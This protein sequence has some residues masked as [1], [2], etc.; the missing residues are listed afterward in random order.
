M[1]KKHF[2][3]FLRWELWMHG[4]SHFIE[5]F[6]AIHEEVCVTASIAT[7]FFTFL[8]ILTSFYISKKHVYLKP[9]E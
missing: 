1:L 4:V 3:G 5:V 2:L 8:E 6:S 7:F 9:I